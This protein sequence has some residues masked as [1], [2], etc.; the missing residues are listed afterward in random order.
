MFDRA[1]FARFLVA[2]KCDIPKAMAHFKEYLQ[3][4]KTAKIDNLLVRQLFIDNVFLGT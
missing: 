3:W 4:R 2:N 1:H